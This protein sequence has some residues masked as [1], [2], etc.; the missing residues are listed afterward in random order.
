MKVRSGS[1]TPIRVSAR[2][3]GNGIVLAQ[4]RSHI[5]LSADEVQ[6]VFDAINSLLAP[7]TNPKGNS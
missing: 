1:G 7:T 5:Q 4:G 6:L 3:N 2:D